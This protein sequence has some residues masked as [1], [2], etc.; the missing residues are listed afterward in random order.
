[1]ISKLEYLLGISGKYLFA[2]DF[3][4]APYLLLFI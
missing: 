3:R 1:M 4:L 2:K